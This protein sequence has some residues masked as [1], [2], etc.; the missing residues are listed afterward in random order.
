MEQADL[1]AIIDWKGSA[2]DDGS[3]PN[4]QIQ[5]TNLSVLACPSQQPVTP[6]PLNID[7]TDSQTTQPPA[8]VTTSSWY[9]RN[10]AANNGIGPSTEYNYTTTEAGTDRKTNLMGV[11]YLNS[12]LKPA[13]ITDGLS[14]TVFVSEICA[15]STPTEVDQRGLPMPEG[16]LYNHNYTPNSST[17]DGLRD[18]IPNVEGAPCTASYTSYAPP[19]FILTARSWHPGGVNALLGDGSVQFISDSIAWIT[20]QALSSPAALPGE[21]VI[22][23]GNF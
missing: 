8:G 14:N 23:G 6:M 7:T 11:F 9:Y 21:E 18:C 19:A 17:P 16:M 2:F 15:V 12:W 1:Y 20:W 13:D 3:W 5:N 22:V 10:Y 4:V